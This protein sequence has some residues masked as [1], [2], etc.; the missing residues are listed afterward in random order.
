MKP[1]ASGVWVGVGAL[2][3]ALTGQGCCGP[4]PGSIPVDP[5]CPDGL[6]ASASL[7]IHLS[8]ANIRPIGSP[9]KIRVRGN[10]LDTDP[11]IQSGASPSFSTELNEPT[12]L[13]ASQANLAPG[14]W[15]LT[16]TALSGG[17]YEPIEANRSLTPGSASTMQISGD[18]SQ[19]IVVAF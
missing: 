17:D 15:K 10:R 3:L 6:K 14:A 11:C 1:R 16:I 12:P 8:P 19:N 2:W 7:S 13:D 9:K 5:N 18:A 4:D